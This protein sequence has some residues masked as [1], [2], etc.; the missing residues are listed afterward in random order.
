[1][2]IPM[3]EGE[4]EGKFIFL[5]EVKARHVVPLHESRLW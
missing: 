3:G 2:S 1:M 4:G 5:R